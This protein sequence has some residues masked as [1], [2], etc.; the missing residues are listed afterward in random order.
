M[1]ISLLGAGLIAGCALESRPPELI[2]RL[3]AQPD[4]VAASLAGPQRGAPRMQVAPLQSNRPQGESLG[5]IVA[6]TT[7]PVV[8]VESFADGRWEEPPETVIERALLAALGDSPSDDSSRTAPAS[9]GTEPRLQ[10]SLEQFELV[11]SAG[12]SAARVTV[13]ISFRLSAAH[14]PSAV[15]EGTVTAQEPVP[16]GAPVEEVVVAF[17]RATPRALLQLI[18]RLRLAV[19]ELPPAPAPA[20]ADA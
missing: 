20:V 15:V 16:V 4:D 3:Q 12:G 14:S 17:N 2:Y 5:I 7:G 11:E 13:A 10:W 8:R 9:A 1:L 18:E 6:Q 19:A